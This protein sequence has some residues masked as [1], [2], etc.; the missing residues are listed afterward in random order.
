MAKAQFGTCHLKSGIELN[1]PSAE[2]GAPSYCYQGAANVAFNLNLDIRFYDVD[3]ET[4]LPNASKLKKCI[5][6]ATKAIFTVGN[7]GNICDYEEIENVAKEY[8]IQILEDAAE[9]Y[10][11]KKRKRSGTFGAI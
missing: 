1:I 7:Y 4:F 8:N 11:T 6:G 9:T 10:G 2:R 3:V 5:S